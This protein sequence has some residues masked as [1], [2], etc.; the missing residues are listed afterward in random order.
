MSAAKKPS[1]GGG[2]VQRL[3]CTRDGRTVYTKPVYIPH[4]ETAACYARILRV[5]A[6]VFFYDLTGEIAVVNRKPTNVDRW[7][8]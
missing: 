1:G 6:G 3:T 5:H 4:A 2:V 8:D 7:N